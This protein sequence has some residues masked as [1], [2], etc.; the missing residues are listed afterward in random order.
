MNPND[1]NQNTAPAQNNDLPPLPMPPTSTEVPPA[2]PEQAMPVMP[3]TMP[4]P[5]RPDEKR[6][7]DLNLSANE[8]IISEITRSSVGLAQLY[9]SAVLAIVVLLAFLY[10]I[11]ANKQILGLKAVSDTGAILAVA[12]LALIVGLVTTV[13]ANIYKMNK[14]ILTTESL[15]I[16]TQQGLFSVAKK[17]ISLNKIEDVSYQQRGVLQSMFGY[18]TITVS[19]MGDEG[20]EFRMAKSPKTHADYINNAHEEF[21]RRH[22]AL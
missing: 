11:I 4:A 16:Q 2:N 3:S 17:T 9:A 12:C 21:E 7:R 1:P 22:A 8:G 5:K 19:T 14:M 10:L 15:I 20:L 13:A 18:G 6:C